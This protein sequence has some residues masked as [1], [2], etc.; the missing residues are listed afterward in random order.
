MTALSAAALC[1]LAGTPSSAAEAPDA[2]PYFLAQKPGMPTSDTLAGDGRSAQSL[3]LARDVELGCARPCESASAIADYRRRVEDAGR[4]LGATAGQLHFA[5]EHYIPDGKP[6]LRDDSNRVNAAPSVEA[7]S[8]PEAQNAR[9][10]LDI[11]KAQTAR[12]REIAASLS[13]G[14][15]LDSPGAVGGAPALV[16]GRMS[17]ADIAALNRVPAAQVPRLAPSGAVPSPQAAAS[18]ADDAAKDGLIARSKAYWDRVGENPATSAPERAAAA[19]LVSLF[20]MFNLD[21]YEKSAFRLADTA[22][23]PGASDAQTAKAALSAAGNAA[24]VGVGFLPEAAAG[25]IMDATKLSSLNGWAADGLRLLRPSPE[26]AERAAQLKAAAL[27]RPLTREEAAWLGEHAPGSVILHTTDSGNFASIAGRT[28]TGAASGGRV[29]AT[30]ERFVYGT[31]KEISTVWRQILS[32][33]RLKDGTVVFQGRAAELFRPH[34]VTGVYS[35]LK[36]AAGQMTTDG[37]GD[38]VIT[39]AFYNAESKTLSIL[40]ARMAGA[41]EGK[42]LLQREGWARARLWG[43]RL[44]L[45]PALTAGTGFAVAAGAS[46]GAVYQY[47]LPGNG[48]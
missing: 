7:P 42:F 27:E 22:A 43:R 28:E 14:S 3:A 45:D 37:A 41:D 17:A 46:D 32:G 40:D 36:R 44:L 47:V 38:I 11:S 9:R 34:E 6:R 48:R 15:G 30:T 16:G 33:A 21:G 19:I 10:A 23:A 12:A 24:L 18:A 31:R 4:A 35:L 8:R 5:V 25:K 2:L 1:L 39:K 29:A 20:K 26:I 13:S